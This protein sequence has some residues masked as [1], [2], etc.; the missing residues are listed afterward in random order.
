MISQGLLNL[1]C[2]RDSCHRLPLACLSRFIIWRRRRG[3]NPQDLSVRLI[4]SQ[5]QSP[6]ICLR[7]HVSPH[8]ES[9]RVLMITSHLHRQQCFGGGFITTWSTTKDSHLVL[10]VYETGHHI[11]MLVVHLWSRYRDLRPA[12]L[13]TKQPCRYLHFTGMWQRAA[14]SKRRQGCT[15]ST[16]LSRHVRGPARFTLYVLAGRTRFELV[17]Q[18]FGAPHATVTPTTHV[19]ED[20]GF[21]PQRVTVEPLSR[22]PSSPRQHHLPFSGSLMPDSN[23]RLRFCRPT[24]EPLY[25]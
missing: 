10:P 14:Y 5:V 1:G 17:P 4:S 21:E 18:E 16:M 22:R 19:A 8:P 3:S 24:H 12:L 25:Q 9:D 13:L 7:L 2:F 6:A 15:P 23:Q 11:S 20:G